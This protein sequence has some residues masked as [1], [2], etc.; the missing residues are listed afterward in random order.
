VVG[1]FERSFEMQPLASY[2]RSIEILLAASATTVVP[3]VTVP[4]LSIA[5]DADTYAPPEFVAAFLS[6]LP[7][8]ATNVVLP[9]V[10]HLPFFEAPEEFARLI[11]DFLP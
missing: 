5:G 8:A 11:G 2:L 3:T 9:D 7:H 10:G 6:R 4:V 1:L